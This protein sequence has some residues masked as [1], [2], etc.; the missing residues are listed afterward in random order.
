M[1]ILVGY[2]G[3]NLAKKALKL[4]QKHAKVWDAKIEVVETIT[5]ISPLDY[6]YIQK[7]EDELE[8]DVRTILNGDKTPY[9][10]H[11]FVGTLSAGEQLVNF[12]ERNKV[13]E[14]IVGARKRSRS[15]KLLFGSTTQYVVLNAP[16]PVVTVK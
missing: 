7:V 3:S 8:W 12:A 15:G 11:L 9:E 13:N 4:A 2:D 14:T 10:T 5:R 1:K 6:Q 16:C